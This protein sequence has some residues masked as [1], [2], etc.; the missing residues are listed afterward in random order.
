MLWKAPTDPQAC[1]ALIWT[2]PWKPWP[3]L[4]WGPSLCQRLRFLIPL[5][6]I[7][8][9]QEIHQRT[10]LNYFMYYAFLLDIRCPHAND[11]CMLKRF[12]FSFTP[13]LKTHS[14]EECVS[15]LCQTHCLFSKITL[16]LLHAWI[17]KCAVAARCSR[18]AEGTNILPV[19]VNGFFF[20][21]EKERVLTT[22]TPGEENEWEWRRGR[23]GPGSLSVF[24]LLQF[25]RT[26]CDTMAVWCL[27]AILTV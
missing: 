16:P 26:D 12:G 18:S 23:S 10:I 15:A 25:S 21:G 6:H 13:S 8:G 1:S 19:S 22:S 24:L 14:R 7:E 3:R 4:G 11:C 9:D 17:A 2:N 5:S 20:A 27:T